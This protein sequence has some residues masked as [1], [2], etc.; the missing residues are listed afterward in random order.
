[1]PWSTSYLASS[2]RRRPWP[3]AVAVWQVMQPMAEDSTLWM[4]SNDVAE[5]VG[6]AAVVAPVLVVAHEAVKGVDVGAQAVVEGPVHQGGV[7]L[8]QLGQ[9]LGVAGLAAA[10]VGL[11]VVGVV[12]R[13]GV[14]VPVAAARVGGALHLAAVL[15]GG[16]LGGVVGGALRLV[17]VDVL[18]AQ[19]LQVLPGLLLGALGRGGG[20]LVGDDV[21]G[22]GVARAHSAGDADGAQ[23]GATC[24]HQPVPRRSCHSP[25]LPCGLWAERGLS[26]GRLLLGFLVPNPS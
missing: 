3:P 7:A 16:H 2:H 15:E 1:M 6:Y 24:G 5:R 20:A 11:E 17:V 19:A 21:R 14:V 22:G 12:D 18:D 25:F 23:G 26:P 10:L 4:P 13:G 9:A 8:E